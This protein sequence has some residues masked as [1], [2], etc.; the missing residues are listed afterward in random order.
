MFKILQFLPGIGDA[1]RKLGEILGDRI[2]FLARFL[3]QT[4]LQIE[5]S[6]AKAMIGIF[7][8]AD[9]ADHL[10]ELIGRD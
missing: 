4:C 2:Q 9:L 6:D 8:V 5:A 7:G 3:I 1:S 10:V